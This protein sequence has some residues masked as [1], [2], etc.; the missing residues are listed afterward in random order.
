MKINQSLKQYIEKNIFPEYSKNEIGHGLEHIKNVI[1]KSFKIVKDNKLDVNQDIVYVVAAYHD[2]G[3]HI[4]SKTHEIISAEIMSKDEN[5]KEFFDDDE[6]VV[7]KEAIED[8][9]ASAKRSPRS[10]Y[11]R[12]VSTA[13]RSGS[14]EEC[15]ERT[16][17]YGQKLLPGATDDEL[18]ENAYNALTKKF[19]ENGYAKHYYK[20]SSY[21]NFLRDI[22]KLLQDKDKFKKTQREYIENLKAKHQ[23]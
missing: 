20:D 8:H 7:I 15:L 4:D 1:N 2:I 14:I 6:L 23:I 16:Y 10:V 19:G 22:R 12:I 9:R 5:L 17:A 3:H 13:D 21:D 18:F 11:G